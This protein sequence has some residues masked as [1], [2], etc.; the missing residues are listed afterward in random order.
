MAF[1]DPTDFLLIFGLLVHRS[2]HS[3]FATYA[4]FELKSYV[5]KNANKTEILPTALYLGR[6]YKHTKRH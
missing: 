2:E 4:N 6:N 1:F 5:T 3:N